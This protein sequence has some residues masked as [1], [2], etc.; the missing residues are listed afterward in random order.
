[1]GAQRRAIRADKENK[2]GDV[3]NAF[4]KWMYITKILNAQDKLNE[5]KEKEKDKERPIII[6]KKEIINVEFSEKDRE[7]EKK[8]TVYQA[9][10]SCFL[11]VTEPAL[12][13]VTLRQPRAMLSVLEYISRMYGVDIVRDKLIFS[14]VK[15][16][17]SRYEQRFDGHIYSVEADGRK[18]SFS[19]DGKEI[20]AGTGRIR[21]ASSSAR[22]FSAL[23]FRRSTSWRAT[24]VWGRRI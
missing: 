8:S 5:D 13:G 15:G 10:L 21:S 18:A 2:K 12:F 6:E 7:K 22:H 24:P 11:G 1:M 19:I 14:C 23:C 17:K 9:A 20:W 3:R 4:N 16:A